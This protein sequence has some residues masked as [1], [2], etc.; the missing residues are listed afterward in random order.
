[1]DIYPSSAIN[2]TPELSM[3]VLNDGMVIHC[4]AL[5]SKREG[6]N[7]SSTEKLMD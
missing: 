4:I 1:M 3:E 7:K 6:F 5:Y 2:D